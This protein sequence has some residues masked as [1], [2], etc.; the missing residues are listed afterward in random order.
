MDST[1][2]RQEE[3]HKKKRRQITPDRVARLRKEAYLAEPY[4]MSDPEYGTFDGDW[5]IIDGKW[6]YTVTEEQE[7]REKATMARFILDQLGIP[8]DPPEN[9]E[10]EDFSKYQPKD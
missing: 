5:I 10:P 2:R 4:T 3:E 1:F 7:L 9:G 6:V 8:L